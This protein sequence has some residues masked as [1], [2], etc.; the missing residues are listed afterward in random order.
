MGLP[1]LYPQLP[2]PTGVHPRQKRRFSPVLEEASAAQTILTLNDTFGGQSY[3]LQDIFPEERHRIMRL[4]SQD[5]LLRLGPALLPRGGVVYRDNYGIWRAFHRDG[6]PV[7]KELQG[8]G[9]H[10]PDPAHH[11]SAAIPGERNQ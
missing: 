3:N 4:L 2:F 11:G 7:P 10:R 1:L 9:R 8:G 6:L 5:T